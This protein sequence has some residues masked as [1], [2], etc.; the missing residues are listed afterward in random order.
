MYERELP[1]ALM[2]LNRRIE[3]EFLQELAQLVSDYNID[4]PIERLMLLPLIY[5]K[6]LIRVA[7]YN[8]RLKIIPQHA[9]GTYRVDF[10]IEFWRE[11]HHHRSCIIECDGHNYH[12]RTKEQ[13]R[14]DKQRDRFL[15]AQGYTVFHFTGS[16]LYRDLPRC[17]KEVM[18]FLQGAANG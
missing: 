1:H 18:D 2:A 4:S 10:F 6:L 8:E 9:I 12:E 16:E 3:K 13:A 7:G 14:R 15:Q 5:V 17:G 11:D